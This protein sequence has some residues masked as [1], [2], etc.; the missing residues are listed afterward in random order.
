MAPPC[1]R[2]LRTMRTGCGSAPVEL[3]SPDMSHSCAGDQAEIS[4][5]GTRTMPALSP[6]SSM[7][8]DSSAQM[9]V[10]RSSL[11]ARQSG[12][13][14]G[15]HGGG[16][17]RQRQH[18][19]EAVLDVPEAQHAVGA[20]AH[21]ELKPLAL[22][23]H[24]LGGRAQTGQ[25]DWTECACASGRTGG[26]VLRTHVM[27]STA[28]SVGGEASDTSCLVSTC[29][30]I[31]WPSTPAVATKLWAGLT[32]LA[33]PSAPSPCRRRRRRRRR[34]GRSGRAQGA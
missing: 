19:L 25:L 31:T 34:R 32:S 17:G 18:G 33:R 14:H 6:V 8:L 24:E 20:R 4:A 7:S 13:R 10:T 11:A 28:A 27:Q 15:A 23:R 3:V 5:G 26:P 29:H 22:R 9:H 1:A 30:S 16:V 2:Q 21:Q 12:P